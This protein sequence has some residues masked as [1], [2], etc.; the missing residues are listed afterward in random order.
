MVRCFSR[1]NLIGLPPLH[2][3][4]EKYSNTARPKIDT[5]KIFFR[6]LL[7][8]GGMTFQGFPGYFSRSKENPGL[9][10][11]VQGFQGLLATLILHK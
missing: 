11:V 7:L 6:I 3:W 2:Y 10:R 4:S 9:F 8:R 1:N 5:W